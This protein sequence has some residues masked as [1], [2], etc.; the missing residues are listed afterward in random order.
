MCFCQLRT[1]F[2][3]LFQLEKEKIIS[4]NTTALSPRIRWWEPF[5]WKGGRIWN[6]TPFWMLTVTSL[7]AD[8]NPSICGV[9]KLS[10]L[11]VQ[12]ICKELAAQSTKWQFKAP[13]S[14]PF[15]GASEPLIQSVKWTLLIF[16]YQKD[17]M[18]TCA[19]KSWSKQKLWWTTLSRWRRISSPGSYTPFQ[20]VPSRQSSQ[21]AW[22]LKRMFNN[23]SP[24]PY[25]P[26]LNQPGKPIDRD[27]KTKTNRKQREFT[28]RSMIW[29][30]F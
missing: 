3:G 1:G 28:L 27:K 23:S 13:D 16:P 20:M 5:I 21:S 10:R 18:L 25:L 9:T 2:F 12:G 24:Q 14:L 19:K 22:G 8:A 26:L 7:Q 11:L 17:L 15:G 29:N 4:R 6:E 30:G